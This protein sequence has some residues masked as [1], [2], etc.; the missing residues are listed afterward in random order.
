MPSEPGKVRVLVDAASDPD[1]PSLWQHAPLQAAL[2]AL[3]DNAII[4]AADDGI[5][6]ACEHGNLPSVI[7][8]AW[9][10]RVQ[11][12]GAERREQI[13]YISKLIVE[14]VAER[15]RLVEALEKVVKSTEG[16]VHMGSYRLALIH[17]SA[18]DALDA[19]HGEQE[20]LQRCETCWADPSNAPCH[21]CGQTPTTVGLIQFQTPPAPDGQEDA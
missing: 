18:Q 16:M 9:Q 13:A 10:V 19:V 11:A 15:Y 4:K 1:A 17:D 14:H 2:N 5:E 8:G 12:L 6:V 3:V 21:V 7:I 20:V